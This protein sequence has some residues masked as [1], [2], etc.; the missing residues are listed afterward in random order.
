MKFEYDY[1]AEA[2]I[3]RLQRELRKEK[4]RTQECQREIVRLRSTVR[5]YCESEVRLRAMKELELYDSW[6]NFSDEKTPPSIIKIIKALSLGKRN[7]AS[8]MAYCAGFR[9]ATSFFKEA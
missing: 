1:D 7:A 2:E 8:F 6:A 9:K 4:E 5:K 3:E